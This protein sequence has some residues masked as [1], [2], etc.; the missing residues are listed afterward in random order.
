MTHVPVGGPDN[1][2]QHIL[3]EDQCV[4]R[5][6]SNN[7]SWGGV[8]KLPMHLLLF[9]IIHRHLIKVDQHSVQFGFMMFKLLIFGVKK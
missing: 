4:V 5:R 2:L 6:T 1:V 3:L 9:V 8:D 7:R